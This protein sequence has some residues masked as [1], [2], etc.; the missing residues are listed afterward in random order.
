MEVRGYRPTERDLQ[1]LD[2]MRRDASRNS[3]SPAVERRSTEPHRSTSATAIA[4]P[5]ISRDRARDERAAQS[6]LR[7]IEAV[8]RTALFD[9][10]AAIKRVM[11]VAQSR[12]DE[13]LNAGREIRPAMVRQSETRKVEEGRGKNAKA[14]VSPQRARSR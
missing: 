14:R 8:V 6:Q 9:D 7:V 1:E 10:P 5:G 11:K 4:P 2:R 12:M 13:K 3:V